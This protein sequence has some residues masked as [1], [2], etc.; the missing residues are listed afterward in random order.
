L[1]F[2]STHKTDHEDKK[3]IIIRGEK[4]LKAFLIAIAS[5]F[6]P[7]KQHHHSFLRYLQNLPSPGEG[8]RHR[9]LCGGR[10]QSFR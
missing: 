7:S 10:R 1:P 2:T 8:C 9:L 4:F 6:S 5:L 3:E